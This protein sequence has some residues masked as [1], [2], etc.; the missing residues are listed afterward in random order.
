MA[1]EDELGPMVKAF[2]GRLYFNLSQL[3]RVCAL[4]GVAPAA[5]L[6]S[7]GHAEAIQPSDEIAPRADPAQL[8]AH[9][10][11]IC[12]GICG[13][14]CAPPA[15]IR[16]ARGEHA[17][18]I[19]A[20]FAAVDPRRLSDA[21]DLVARSSEWS[22]EAPE[23]MQTVLLLSNVLFHEAPV[24]K[25]CEQVGFPF[26]QLVYPQLAAGRAVGER[27]AG[28]RSRRAGGGRARTSRRS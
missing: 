13:G 9:A 26:E 16:A 24:R 1:P 8:A 20:R 23:Y 22:D 6:R 21:R 12:C 5:M 15:S 3:R 18:A 25:V 7:M 2:R 14:T 27:A 17:R 19:V 11:P 10:C 28:I 4:G